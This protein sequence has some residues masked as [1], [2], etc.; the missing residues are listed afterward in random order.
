MNADSAG[1]FANYTID[2][3]NVEVS[4]ASLEADARTVI[5]EL[6]SPLTPQEPH[7]LT[8]TDVKDL[9][10][11]QMPQ[12]TTMP[13]VLEDGPSHV[14]ALNATL[15]TKGRKWKYG[16]VDVSVLRNGLAVPNALVTG[17]WSGD[18][19]ATSTVAAAADVTG[20]VSFGTERLPSDSAGEL[21]FAVTDIV[22]DIAG[23]YDPALNVRSSACLLMP[24]GLPCEGDGGGEP[25]GG[26][27]DTMSVTELDVALGAIGKSKWSKGTALATVV[28]NDLGSPVSGASVVGQWTLDEVPLGTTTAVT[29]DDGVATLESDKFDGAEQV[30]FTVT[31]V[32]HASYAFD[33][34][35]KEQCFP[36]T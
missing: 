2:D 15:L 16:S 35:Q 17:Q 19:I 6:A 14:G 26:E 20:H 34:Q 18:V 3:T 23:D 30:C 11:N 31:A 9:L 25:P 5:L 7:T 29:S 36:E 8:V 21:R 10:G 12:A 33:G 4:S 13:F 22:T 32:A 28:L 1:N 27:P 24:S